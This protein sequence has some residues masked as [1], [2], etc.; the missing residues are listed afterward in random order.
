MLA[1]AQLPFGF[2]SASTTTIAVGQSR[3]TAT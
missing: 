1:K 2:F 3:K